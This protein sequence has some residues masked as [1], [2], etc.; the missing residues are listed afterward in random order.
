MNIGIAMVYISSLKTIYKVFLQWPVGAIHGIE[1]S[2]IANCG[3]IRA[4]VIARVYVYITSASGV[5]IVRLFT[6]RS[7]SCVYLL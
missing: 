5:R 7:A 3:F 4:D 1:K 2:R 6:L